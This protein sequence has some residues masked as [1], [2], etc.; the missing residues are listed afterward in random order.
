MRLRSN[1]LIASLLTTAKWIF[2]GT[3]ILM[4]ALCSLKLLA[5]RVSRRAA[6]MV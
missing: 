1:P 3:S 4:I 6:S 2:G 5:I